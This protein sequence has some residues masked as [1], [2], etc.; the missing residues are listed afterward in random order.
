MV[1][2]LNAISKYGFEIIGT[3]ARKLRGYWNYY[4]ITGN[5]D[6]LQNYYDFTVTKY[7]S[8]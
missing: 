7:S 5:Y 3:L 1:G 8:R 2:W 4:G 6:S